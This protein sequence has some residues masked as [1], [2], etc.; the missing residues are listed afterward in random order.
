MNKDDEDHWTAIGQISAARPEIEAMVR[1]RIDALIRETNKAWADERRKEFLLWVIGGVERRVGWANF[2]HADAFRRMNIL[3]ARLYLGEREE[4]LDFLSRLRWELYSLEH[5]ELLKDR[6]TEDEKMRARR[7]PFQK[8]IQF[9]REGFAPCPFHAERTPSLHLK[10]SA[11]IIYCF[12][13]C[14]RGWDTIGYLMEREGITF[15]EAVR[16]LQ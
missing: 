5:P 8:L 15:P 2:L 7:Y 4:C 10:R 16:R 12:G 3:E 13:A 11:N 1:R 9:N 6:I 14:G